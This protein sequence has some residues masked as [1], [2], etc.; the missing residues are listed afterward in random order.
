MNTSLRVTDRNL[1]KHEQR[2]KWDHAGSNLTWSMFT[3]HMFS[4]RRALSRARTPGTRTPGTL[5]RRDHLRGFKSKFQQ[6]SKELNRGRLLS[7]Y[8]ELS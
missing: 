7:G 2:P 8:S 4:T 1:S 5:I 6:I 3:D